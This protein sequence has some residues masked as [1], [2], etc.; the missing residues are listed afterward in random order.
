M[1]R[2][3]GRVLRSGEI[4]SEPETVLRDRAW[5]LSVIPDE[6]MLYEFYR[7]DTATVIAPDERYIEL[8]GRFLRTLL[9]AR[10]SG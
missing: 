3:V 1:D 2:N 4:G 8:D 7:Q 6:Y 5:W 10:S 9:A